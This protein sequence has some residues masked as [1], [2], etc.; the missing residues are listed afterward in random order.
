MRKFI[1]FIFASG[2]GTR[3]APLTDATPKPLLPLN[4]DLSMLDLILCRLITD[5]FEEAFV[6]YSY[7]LDLFEKV[8]SK[9]EEKICIHLVEDTSVLGHG[10][11]LLKVASLFADTGFVL[12][13]NGDTYAGYNLDTLK[14]AV[15]PLTDVCIFCD[16]SLEELP[17]TLLVSKTQDLLG[18]LKKDGSPYFYSNTPKN[19]EIIYRNNPGMCV[20][21]TH[22]LKSACNSY[23]N[24]FLGFFGENDLFEKLSGMKYKVKVANMKYS[25]YFSMNTPKDYSRLKTLFSGRH[26][27]C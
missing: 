20:V 8:K 4:A 12:G 26:C 25:E 3:L 14:D 17:K 27:A 11:I 10:G 5:G 23:D 18:I 16:D 2:K 21:S 6:N 13:I 24:S 7:R 19:P 9:Y 22:A 15:N 1:P